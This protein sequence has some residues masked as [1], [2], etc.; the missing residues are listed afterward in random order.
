MGGRGMPP[1]GPGWGGAPGMGRGP[2]MGMGMGMGMNQGGLFLLFDESNQASI[3]P[4]LG[5]ESTYFMYMYFDT[6][7]VYLAASESKFR[8]S[9]HSRKP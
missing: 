8:D 9:A 5:R 3:V 6:Q 4:S 7:R 1:G 2:G